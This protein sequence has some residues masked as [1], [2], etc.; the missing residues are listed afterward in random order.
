V[1]G[2]ALS[3]ALERFA[4]AADRA[5]A[6]DAAWRIVERVLEGGSALGA[7]APEAVA[8]IAALLGRASFSWTADALSVVD[9]VA[10]NSGQWRRAALGSADPERFVSFVDLEDETEE[11]LRIVEP[12]IRRVCGAA[13]PEVR[14]MAAGTLG[15]VSTDPAADAALFR[16]MLDQED[17][18]LVRACVVEAE[19]LL[20]ARRRDGVLFFDEAAVVRALRDPSPAVRYRVARAIRGRTTT[21]LTSLIESAL[22]VDAAEQSALVWPAEV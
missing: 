7:A 1:T 22:A 8:G 21:E 3:E 16:A 14:A 2:G 19:V 17:H 12:V 6:A 15:L 18:P 10:A 11:E 5:A 9:T 20:G 13:D 4:R